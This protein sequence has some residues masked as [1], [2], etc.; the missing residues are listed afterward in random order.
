MLP[1]LNREGLEPSSLVDIMKVVVVAN[2][3]VVCFLF[4]LWFFAPN[5]LLFLSTRTEVDDS[6]VKITTFKITE[7]EVVVGKCQTEALP[8]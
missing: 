2:F 7:S 6:S 3:I 8:Y 4:S 1:T 5:I